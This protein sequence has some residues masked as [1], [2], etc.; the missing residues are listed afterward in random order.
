MTVRRLVRAVLPIIA[1]VGITSCSVFSQA[2]HS[3]PIAEANTKKVEKEILFRNDIVEE[4]EEYLGTRYRSAGK[5]PSGFDC[6]GLVYFV[7][8]E[9]DIS[10]NSSA[11][12]QEKQGVRISKKEAKP[13]DL[14]FFRRSLGGRVFHVAMVYEN[15]KSGM[16]LIHSTSRGVVIDKLEDSAYWRSKIMT[17]RNVVNNKK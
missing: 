17:F 15:D 1:L 5:S 8:K 13:G 7:M 11:A 10:M 6:S 3:G 9:H 14:V 16:T 4:A 2:L 12:T